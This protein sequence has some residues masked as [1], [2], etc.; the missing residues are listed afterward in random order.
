MFPI[1]NSVDDD[2][3]QK[4]TQARLN[5]AKFQAVRLIKKHENDILCAFEL[6]ARDRSEKTR[7]VKVDI[8]RALSRVRSCKVGL[9]SENCWG[10][11][12]ECEILINERQEHTRN[13]LIGTVLHEA[14]HFVCKS[15]RGYGLRFLAT[16]AEHAAMTILGEHY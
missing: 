13:E 1:I 15:C 9:T 5:R 16:D 14:L 11:S 10:E 12:D 4:V 2:K 6:A 8:E 7:R 3:R